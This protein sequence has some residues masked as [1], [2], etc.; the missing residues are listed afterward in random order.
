[1]WRMRTRSRRAMW[2]RGVGIVSL[3]LTM[4]SGAGA[5]APRGPTLG[6][7]LS[8]ADVAELRQ[9]I[10]PD[11]SGLPPGRGDVREG[12]RLYAEHC[13]AC[14]GPE[15]RGA[16]ADEL[17]GGRM[18]LDS[19]TPDKVIGTYWPYAT[20]LFDFIAR[21]MP[22]N[23]PKTLSADQVYAVSAYLLYLNGLLAEDAA[24]DAA[25][26]AA[27]RMP[28]RDGFV[29]IDAPSPREPVRPQTQSGGVR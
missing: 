22:L 13:R 29:W 18:S 8:G 20:T 10:Y 5:D 23:A 27:I 7:K 11:G 17:A 14:H 28:N 19:D 4:A 1:M 26:L 21:A 12:A 3:W 24:L 16:S 25:S 9:T 15:G 6:R 2:I